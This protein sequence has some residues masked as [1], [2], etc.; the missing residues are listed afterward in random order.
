LYLRA[1]DHVDRHR[2]NEIHALARWLLGN[3]LEGVTDLM[4]GYTNLYLEYDS[5]RLPEP[6]LLSWVGKGVAN[7]AVANGKP[8]RVEI[9]VRYDGADLAG[10]GEQ[11]GLSVEEVVRRHSAVDYHV[12][13]MGFTPGFP[14]LGEVDESIR[15]PR[16]PTPRTRVPAHSLAL[17]NNQT[18]IYPL[19]SPG[20]WNLLG[21]VLEPLFDPHREPPFLLEPGDLVSFVP[22][23]GATPPLPANLELL[24][25]E[26]RRPF[27]RVVRSGLLDLIVDEGRFLAG[28]FGLSRSGPLDASLARLANS[29]VGNASSRPLVELTM[30]GPRL[31]ALPMN[32]SDSTPP[33][34][35]R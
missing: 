30:T 11:T 23:E 28:R 18:G 22:A 8:R 3:M 29:L 10:I 13:A 17:A 26:P 14:F 15:V 7:A 6:E 32:R 25:P 27:L 19:P 1:G 34:I 9:P 5:R 21:T 31:E 24:P 35:A 20:G 2:N 33:A 16:R 12:F 4:P